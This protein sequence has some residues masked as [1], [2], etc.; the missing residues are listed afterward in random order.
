MDF[1]ESTITTT[2][3]LP[4]LTLN[5]VYWRGS[6]NDFVY[7]PDNVHFAPRIKLVDESLRHPE[8]I[9]AQLSS[10]LNLLAMLPAE[11]ECKLYQRWNVST[12]PGV[13][14]KDGCTDENVEKYRGHHEAQ[15]KSVNNEKESSSRYGLNLDGTGFSERYAA[16]LLNDQLI[17]KVDTPFFNFYSRFFLPYKHYIPVKYDLSDLSEKVAWANEHVEESHRIMT[18]GARLAHSLFHPDEVFC[19]TGLALAAFGRLLGYEVSGMPR[20]GVDQFEPED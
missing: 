19:Y 17:F 14:P 5:R 10:S 8:L 16:Q 6:P 15:Q 3:L 1:R 9:D 13:S 7:E 20:E 11:D 18:Q 2:H 4:P 12:P